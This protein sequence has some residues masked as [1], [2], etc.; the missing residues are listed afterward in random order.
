M[1]ADHITEARYCLPGESSWED[2]VDRVQD[3]WSAVQAPKSLQ[4]TFRHYM[5]Q[6]KVIPGGRI[7]RNAGLKKHQMANCF[8]FSVEDSREGWGEL[9]Q[10][11]TVTLMTG[12]GVGVDY[13]QIRGS[14]LVLGSTIGVA[15]GPVPLIRTV[16]EIGR[17]VQCGGFRR[18]ALYASLP[19]Y[20]PD[21]FAF[22]HMKDWPQWLR[23]Q[24][25]LDM[26]VAAPGDMTNISVRLNASFFSAYA[27]PR[28]PLHAHAR[29]VYNEA[30]KQMLL[31]G[32]PGF[33]ID[34]DN[35]IL[36]NA[37]TEIISADDSDSC[38]LAAL[39]FARL[40]ASEVEEATHAAT[41]FL[42]AVTEYNHSPTQE[43]Y[44]VQQRNRRLGLGVMGV[45][46]WFIARD[47]PYGSEEI[48]PW[49]QAYKHASIASAKR[50]SGSWGF[51]MPIAIRAI[52][53]TGTISIV[54][55]TTSGI[56]PMF[57]PAYER[58]Y[59]TKTGFKTEVLV[60]PLAAKWF[61]QGRTI[62]DYAHVIPH[63]RR[64]KFQA[65]VQGYI[66]NG[67]SST[68]N[69]PDTTTDSSVFGETLMQYLPR[70]RGI[71]AFP[72]GSRGLQPITPVPLEYGLAHLDR[73]EMQDNACP[74]GVCSV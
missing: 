57:A 54:A 21:I 45:G 73:F 65:D 72:N 16:N 69:L 55:A 3:V 38:V 27:K 11:A 48:Y 35:Q 5:L 51:P 14:G 60:D 30:V 63:E 61:E 50:W 28:H 1:F 34:F 22:I 70:L 9:T 46:E 19:W 56:E 24:K 59:L 18:S 43:C 71:T 26:E 39:N 42:L 52:A 49:F 2:V 25:A 64:I 67:I 8:L 31:T 74:S 47:L 6:K 36:R 4:K 13:G 58:R 66:D 20:H 32:E 40:D 17:G 44:D 41:A 37:C 12:G 7:L 23:D 15:S 53:P 68:I 29:A 62:P 10:K 33:Q